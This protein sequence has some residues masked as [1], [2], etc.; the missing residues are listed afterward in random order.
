MSYYLEGLRDP[1]ASYVYGRDTFDIQSLAITLD[2]LTDF[3]CVCRH[4]VLNG[5]VRKPQV[6]F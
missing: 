1:Q 3:R 5:L 2:F 4:N 6:F